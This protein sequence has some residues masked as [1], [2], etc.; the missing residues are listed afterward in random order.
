MIRASDA[1]VRVNALAGFIPLA[2]RHPYLSSIQA[3]ARLYGDVVR[4]CEAFAFRVFR[5]RRWRSHTGQSTLFRLA[6]QIHSGAVDREGISSTSLRTTL[7]YYSTDQEFPADAFAL[8]EGA[9][10]DW[11]SW[12]GLKYFLYEYERHLCGNDDVWGVVDGRREGRAREDDRACL[13]PQTPRRRV[14]CIG[15]QQQDR[16]ARC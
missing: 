9:P 6:N 11:Y 13:L 10:F 12:P 2:D 1:L 3:D 4:L 14:V 8:K 16:A 7:H 15:L 5:L